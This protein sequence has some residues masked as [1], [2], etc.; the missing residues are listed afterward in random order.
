M[1]LIRHFR[2]G[3]SGRS[4]WQKLERFGQRCALSDS[5]SLCQ[6]ALSNSMFVRRSSLRKCQEVVCGRPIGLGVPMSLLGRLLGTA[7]SAQRYVGRDAPRTHTRHLIVLPA[8]RNYMPTCNRRKPV[9][10]ARSRLGFITM[11]RRH[12]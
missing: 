9:R 10:G 1:L 4:L 5:G 11:I 6:A 2:K 3:I 12:K 8:R 7:A